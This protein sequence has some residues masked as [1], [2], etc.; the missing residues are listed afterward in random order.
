MQ[1]L[2]T[3]LDGFFFLRVCLFV[4]FLVLKHFRY[5]YVLAWLI[6]MKHLFHYI[7]LFFWLCF[8]MFNHF[9]SIITTWFF[10]FIHFTWADRIRVFLYFDFNLVKFDWPIR[11]ILIQ[12][13]LSLSELIE[14]LFIFQL[15][16][17]I[18]IQR[19]F[20]L[21]SVSGRHWWSITAGIVSI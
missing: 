14:V 17:F 11:V 13:V 6:L 21:L 9:L 18:F 3:D 7:R 5:L 15:L 10:N 12:S 16:Y 2:L 1:H 19:V 8:L 20:R 4:L